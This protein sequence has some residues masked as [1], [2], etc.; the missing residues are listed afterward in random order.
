MKWRD[1]RTIGGLCSVAL[2]LSY[3]VASVSYLLLPPDQ[4]GGTIL[5]E[6][7]RYLASVA[8][9]PAMLVVNHLTFGVGALI[10]IGVVIAVRDWTR[11][12]EAGWMSWLSA[13]GGLG[14]AVTAVDNFQ[15]AAIDPMRAADF[16]RADP[17]ARTALTVTNSLVSIDPQMWLSFGLTGLWISGVSWLAFA[18]KLLPPVYSLLGA[19][20]AASYLLIE[21]AS[22]TGSPALLVASASLGGLVVG[23]VWYLRLGVAL[24]RSA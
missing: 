13:L 4:K 23:P 16:V 15:I 14:F 17:I 9:D 2:G 24:L 7:A 5:H 3:V 10:G 1:A 12:L 19:A 20:A 18:R 6:P 21:I 8:R 22:V 11:H